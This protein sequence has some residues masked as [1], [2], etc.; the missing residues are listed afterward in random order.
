VAGYISE[1]SVRAL[2]AAAASL[3]GEG[4]EQVCEIKPGAIAVHWRGLGRRQAEEVRTKAYRALSTFVCRSEV[5]LSEFDGGIEV[6][7]RQPNKGDAVQAIIAECEKDTP[8]AYLGDDV[9]DEDAFR[10]LNG[11]GLTVLVR[12]MYRFTAARL[13]LRPPGDVIQFLADWVRACE[14]DL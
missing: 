10:A 5:F 12:P 9:S 7:V 4:L 3:E 6:R 1:A 14:G 13:W 8:I 11:R 2:A